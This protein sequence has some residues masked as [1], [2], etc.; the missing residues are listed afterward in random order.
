MTKLREISALLLDA[1]NQLYSSNTVATRATYKY[2]EL[3]KD[4]RHLNPLE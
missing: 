4:K 2:Y 3:N 1:R